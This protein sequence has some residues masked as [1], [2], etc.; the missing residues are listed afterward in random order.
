ME[1][2]FQQWHN[3]KFRIHHDKIRPF[4]HLREVWFCSLGANVGF[5]QDG[6]GKRYL[7]PVLVLRKFNN[8]VLWVLPFTKHGKQGKYY[9]SVKISDSKSPSILILSQIRLIDAKRLQYKI[10]DV[11]EEDFSETKKRL[12]ALLE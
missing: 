2:D 4:F 6:G 8:E 5:E 7:R 11:S 12:R 9:C 3:E 1:K 10:G